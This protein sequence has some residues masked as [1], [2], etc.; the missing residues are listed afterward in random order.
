[1]K[2]SDLISSKLIICKEASVKDML[3]PFR[4]HRSPSDMALAPWKEISQ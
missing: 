4:E 1:M 3:L 2:A